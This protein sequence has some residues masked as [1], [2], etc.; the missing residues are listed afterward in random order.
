MVYKIEPHNVMN[1]EKDPVYVDWEIRNLGLMVRVYCDA[2]FYFRVSCV[3]GRELC[4]V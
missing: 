4:P 2:D 3:K 1:E